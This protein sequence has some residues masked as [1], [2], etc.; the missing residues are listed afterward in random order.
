MTIRSERAVVSGDLARL[1]EGEAIEGAARRPHKAMLYAAIQVA[2]AGVSLGSWMVLGLVASAAYQQP[3]I[4]AY[5]ISSVAALPL[6]LGI[7]YVLPNLFRG[8]AS[9]ERGGPWSA[10]IVAAWIVAAAGVGCGG[11]LVLAAQRGGTDRLA[12]GLG[13][14]AGGFAAASVLGAQVARITERPGLM[15][16]SACGQAVL[17]ITWCL[18]FLAGTSAERGALITLAVAIAGLAVL[19]GACRRLTPRMTPWPLHRGFMLQAI[20]LIPHL[21]L[22]GILMQ[23]LRAASA[24]MT[25]ADLL[26]S[27]QVMLAVT[28]ALTLG[29][30][31]HAIFTVRVQAADT[32]QIHDVIRSNARGYALTGGTIGL[33]LVVGTMI[34]PLVLPGFPRLGP[35]GLI[36]VAAIVP[37]VMMY[38]AASGLALRWGQAWIV[39]TS[40]V[41]AVAVFAATQIA[42]HAGALESR[43]LLYAL[44]VL[45]LPVVCA[46]LVAIVGRG[47]SADGSV[48]AVVRWG[49]ASL[50]CTVGVVAGGA[51]L[52]R[53]VHHG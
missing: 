35:L 28:A 5:A 20:V 11:I 48:R 42:G 38:Y 44:A 51:L 45:V 21:V 13:L 23:G 31:L 14:T 12:I 4:Q 46:G 47:R 17:P 3:A 16:V 49:C 36:A 50:V 40:S 24:G 6:T 25:P 33:A 8:A 53:Q 2:G 9:R 41:C 37:G 7:A 30:S 43:L 34:G 19:V 26:A 10:H 29:G 52:I 27:H 32:P 39:T 15:A 1:V 18:A 22:F